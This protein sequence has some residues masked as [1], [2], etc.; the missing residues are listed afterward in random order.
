MDMIDNISFR[1]GIVFFL[2]CCDFLLAR[3]LSILEI[4]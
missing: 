2:A 3:L 4:H 1:L